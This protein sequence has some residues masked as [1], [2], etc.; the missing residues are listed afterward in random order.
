VTGSIAARVTAPVEA[1]D[2]H[3]VI[4]WRI[5]G[6]QERLYAGSAL[7]SRQGRLKAVARQACVKTTWGI[8]LNGWRRAP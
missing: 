6:D 2:P 1:G 5:G 8:P 3:V 7:F 4:G